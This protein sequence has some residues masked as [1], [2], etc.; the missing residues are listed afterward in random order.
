MKKLTLIAALTAGLSLSAVAATDIAGV[1]V[2]DQIQLQGK[3]L[4][5]SGAGIRSKF[6]MDLYVG[7]LYSA[8]T[9]VDA[10]SVIHGEHASAIRLNIV[11]G[12]IT[13]DK[14][15][16]TIEEGFENAAGDDFDALK[17]QI[18]RFIAVFNDKIVEGD[19]FT[20]LSLPGVGVEAYKNGQLLTLVEGERF[21]QA[22]LGIWLG[23]KPAD[24]DLKQE[25]LGQ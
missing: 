13:S 11:S 14:M 2:N 6:F 8:A 1:K 22:L 19:Q 25:M 7:S 16:D 10:D 21:R 20:L 9:G 18:D 15:I 17:P 12:L 23:N 24:K 3:P 4:T 5:L